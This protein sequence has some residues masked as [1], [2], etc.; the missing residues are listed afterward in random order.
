MFI[1]QDVVARHRQ[2]VPSGVA[3]DDVIAQLASAMSLP[4]PPNAVSR[5]RRRPTACHHPA[6]RRSGHRRR[7]PKF[8]RYRDRLSDDRLRLRRRSCR[9]RC[10]HRSHRCPGHLAACWPVPPS[11][12]SSLR[13]PS[14]VSFPDPPFSVSK[15]SPPSTRSSPSVRRFGHRR[16]P[17]RNIV[18]APPPSIMCSA[19]PSAA[20]SVSAVQDIVRSPPSSESSPTWLRQAGRN[21]R[22]TA[23]CRRPVRH[24]G[25]WC[26][27]RQR[28]CLRRA[29][30]AGCRT[31]RCRPS[32]Q[33]RRRVRSGCVRDHVV[34]GPAIDQR[35]ANDR[36]KSAV[37]GHPSRHRHCS[38]DGRGRCRLAC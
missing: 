3:A 12:R 28:A 11:I 30:P 37:S 29:F 1:Q 9:H 2:R 17:R 32:Q 27:C 38:A 26:R 23:A 24:T 36:P 35:S 19:T 20:Y 10:R 33:P 5:R 34:S 31:R 4:P 14:T 7:R 15:P 18:P 22:A 6:G 21:R 8:R 13:P 25:A 16:L